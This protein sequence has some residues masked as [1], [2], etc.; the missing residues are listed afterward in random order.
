MGALL[1][2]GRRRGRYPSVTGACEDRGVTESDSDVRAE[3]AEV[4]ARRDRDDMAPTIA[5]LHEVLDRFPDS[6][7]ALAEVGGGYDT[8]GQEQAAADHYERALGAGL[9]GEDL[10]QVLL[11]YGSTLRNLGR[12]EESLAV[13]E[14]ARAAFPASESLRAFHALSLHAAGRS[15]AAVAEL[16][17]L[18][19]DAIRS[20]DLQRYERAVRGYAAELADRDRQH[21]ADR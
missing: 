14:D 9:T 18:A 21:L 13:L 6:A 2:L 10:R 17:R 16:L 20:D 1:S 8:A 7:L 19:A 4:L 12:V 5:A 3:L 15:D 11:Q